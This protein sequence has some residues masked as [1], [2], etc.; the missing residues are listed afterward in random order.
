MSDINM[1]LTK[2]NDVSFQVPKLRDD[3][4][5]WSDFETRFWKAL[6]AKG[7]LKFVEGTGT[8]PVMY[9]QDSG[10]YVG[11]DGKTPVTED[12]IEAREAKIEEYV[13]RSYLAQHLILIS[14]SARL[15]SLIKDLKS[16]KDMWDVLKKEATLKSTIHIIDAEHQ[17]SS[18]V[19]HDSSD[20][21]THLTEIKAHLDLMEKRFQNLSSIGSNWDT[22][23]YGQTI[24]GSLPESYRPLVQTLSTQRENGGS[25]PSPSTIYK[26]IVNEAD[27]R[28]IVADRQKGSESAMV[29]KS[30]PKTD[31]S[32][33]KKFA[34]KCFGC[35]KTGHMK[36]DCWQKDDD[37]DDKSTSKKDKKDKKTENVAAVATEENLFAFTCTSDFAGIAKARGIRK[38]DMGAIADSGASRHYSPDKEK[39]I[40][41]QPLTQSE[42][43]T[44]DGRSFRAVG[45]GDLPITLPNGNGSTKSMLLGTI[46]APDFAFTLISIGCLDAAGHT[47]VFGNSACTITS[48]DGTT[49]AILPK[50]QG[51]YR[52]IDRPTDNWV[53]AANLAMD[54]MS[55]TDAHRRFGHI[56][57]EAIKLMIKSKM[58]EGIELDSES[59]PEFCDACAKAKSNVHPFPKESGT[60]SKCYGERVHWDL[61]GPASVRSLAGNSYCAARIDDASRESEVYFQKKKDETRKSY[62]KDE[63]YLENQTGK[64]IKYCRAD[65]G[66]EFMSKELMEHQDMKG[67][68]RELTVHDSPPQNGSSERRMRTRAEQAR[69]MLI[70]S[71]L[72][73]F[74]WEEGFKHSSWLQDRTPTKAL[75]DM[76]PFEFVKKR[77]PNL[78]GLQEFGT[79]A[80]VKK[81]GAG[82]LEERAKIGRF[83]GYDSESKG[84][85]IYW[86]EKRSVTV[87]RNVVFNKNDSHVW[88]DPDV[89]PGSVFAEEE[90]E[91]TVQRNTN[92]TT[93][94]KS[95]EE[96]ESENRQEESPPDD[97][98]PDNDDRNSV[99][100]PTEIGSS[101][102]GM[103]DQLPEPEPNTGRG[104]RTRPPPGAYRRANQGLLAVFEESPT[105]DVADD[106][107]PFDCLP[108]PDPDYGFIGVF[109]DEPKTLNEALGTPEGH[110]WAKAHEY[111]IGRLEKMGVWEI[112]DLPKGSK[113]IPHSEVF[114]DKRGPDGNIEVRRAR[115]VAGGHKQIQEIDYTDTFSAAAKMPSVRLILA[116]A[117]ANDWEIHH[118]DVKSAYLNAPMDKDVYMIPPQGVLKKGQE[119]MVCKI[120]KALYGMKQSGRL[121]HKLL[122]KLMYELGFTRSKIDHSV[123][124]KFIEEINMVIAVATD[125]MAITSKR[126][127]DIVKFKAELSKHVELSDKGELTW[128]L[129][130]EVRR[131]RENRLIAINQR[132]YIEAMVEK[133]GLSD[134]KPVHTPMEVGAQYSKSQ[135]PMSPKQ[136]AA[137]R[138][139]PYAEAIGSVLWP[140]MVSRPDGNC[141]VG[142]LSQFI[143][144]PGPAHWDGVK[145]LISYLGTTKDLWLVFGGKDS[146]DPVGYCDADW[147][148][149]PGRHSISGYSFHLGVGAITWS[150]KKQN[151]VA[152][153]ST[154]AEYIAQNHAVREALWLRRFIAEINNR[155]P[156]TIVLHS[157]N[158]GAIDM[159]KDPKFHSRTKHID[160]R[161]HFIREVVADEMVRLEY[162]PGEENTADIF[163]KPLVRSKLEQFANELG[164]QYIE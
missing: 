10:K 126:L 109:P 41:Y 153:S 103:R 163:T 20:S 131:N 134:A 43:T 118:V 27:H 51:L 137:M 119:G 57:H 160:I 100:F 17:L 116:N 99:P 68:R 56:N 66:G 19:C 31:K 23:R 111:E 59:Q 65:R 64:R 105:F 69:A 21:A 7:L 151:L 130:F 108:T 132:S 161:Y 106:E 124:Y 146:V 110:E 107:S 76:T 138:K 79:A 122:T 61:W 11:N 97:S 81:L 46:H 48:K 92:R 115:I 50:A 44:A 94:D 2:S 58:V 34:G 18:M 88:N 74:M 120:L 67:T 85:R 84:Y 113:A 155:D 62:L 39:F 1:S 4:N 125:D 90:N 128:F 149:Q 33:K 129:G 37:K 142:I 22:H 45:K 135:S 72:P 112:V 71:G 35:G 24:L 156:I 91:T 82:K 157:D 55:I 98:P 8:A 49:M 136:E 164:L 152:L 6:G 140:V 14:V 127:E 15:G 145:R 70:S 73:T 13:R 36:S 78:A 80:Y 53:E 101:R 3:G 30:K 28:V 87:E 117:A 40:N 5:N 63:A 143:Q 75:K 32:A 150:S 12:Q 147:A 38:K 25:I 159:A 95:E 121:W 89:V 60:R 148:S 133:F 47:A 83:V 154:E 144:N 139:V 96:E 93:A 26:M 77:K 16:A 29:A 42:I 141:T 114:K 158:T 52:A 104:F 102:P 9:A 162:I 86:P 54:R 123:F